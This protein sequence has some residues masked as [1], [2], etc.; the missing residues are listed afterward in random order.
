MAAGDPSDTSL[1]IGSSINLANALGSL[2]ATV[3]SA[4]DRALEEDNVDVGDPFVATEG[5]CPNEGE[6]TRHLPP[7]EDPFA[8]TE[9][10]RGGDGEVPSDI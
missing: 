8:I 3:D 2:G 4:P 6:L 9:V 10:P 7:L 5:A 1:N